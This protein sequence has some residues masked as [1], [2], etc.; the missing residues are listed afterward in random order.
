MATVRV[1]HEEYWQVKFTGEVSL[2][3]YKTTYIARYMHLLDNRHG[4]T[5]RWVPASDGGMPPGAYARMEQD[6]AYYVR[7]WADGDFYNVSWFKLGQRCSENR[8]E[9]V[10]CSNSY[11]V[12]VVDGK[13]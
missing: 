4:I 10:P 2:Y 8:T 5:Y 9:S 1:E 3:Y 6:T 13:F 7:R 11:D 12:L